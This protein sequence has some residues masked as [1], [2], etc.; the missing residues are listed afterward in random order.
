MLAHLGNL[1]FASHNAAVSHP[2]LQADILQRRRNNPAAYLQNLARSIE[3]GLHTTFSLRHRRNKQI[4][5]AMPCKRGIALK[6]ILHQTFHQRLTVSKSCQAVTQITG[7]NNT[8]LLTQ[9]S[10]GTAVISSCYYGRT[11]IGDILHAAQQR[12]Q[13]GTATDN[14]DSRAT[15][16]LALHKNRFHQ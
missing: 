4:A 16:Q 10:G 3:S 7:R 12:R 14:G 1:G 8:Q 2:C 13:T 5:E 15:C 9:T 11:I 6:A